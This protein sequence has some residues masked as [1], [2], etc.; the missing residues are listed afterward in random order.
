MRRCR[1]RQAPLGRVLRRV[2]YEPAVVHRARHVLVGLLA[3]TGSLVTS[4]RSAA[5]CGQCGCP[6]LPTL[7]PGWTAHDAV[8]LNARFLL[9]TLPTTPESPEIDPDGVRWVNDAD[10]SEIEI[11]IVPSG[12]NDQQLW[13]VPRMPLAPNTGYRI[14]VGAPTDPGN[15][16]MLFTTGT[17]TDDTGPVLGDAR[18]LGREVSSFC[19]PFLGAFI[20][21]DSAVDAAFA[22][23]A[24]VVQLEVSDGDT[25]SRQYHSV[26]NTERPQE[27]PLLAALDSAGS[28]CLGLNAIPEG[29][30]DR[31]YTVVATF[32]DM[33]GN[34]AELP[35]LSFTLGAIA[36]ASCDSGVEPDA[37]LRGPEVTEPSATNPAQP[38]ASTEAEP[39][40]DAVGGNAAMQAAPAGVQL[41]SADDRADTGCAMRAR[42]AANGSTLALV[43]WVLAWRRRNCAT[44]R[45]CRT[46]TPQE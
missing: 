18:V 10:G 35:P 42:G 24:L 44:V 33:A 39:S 22:A 9:T 2:L 46:P 19:E 6:R 43:L 5:A 23:D 7:V 16:L 15:V 34:P 26:R 36:A 40:V 21:V 11:E 1:E 31:E 30:A 29:A 3:I 13:L 28:E 12:A 17:D 20:E 32:Y 41:E 38:N 14:E 45:A 8:P 37:G 4:P 25:T 27:I